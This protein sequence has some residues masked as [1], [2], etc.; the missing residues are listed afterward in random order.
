MNYE[1]RGKLRHSKKDDNFLN[2]PSFYT[3]RELTILP[4]I[5][6]KNLG[7]TKISSE[8]LAGTQ[9]ICECG[10]VKHV[11]LSGCVIIFRK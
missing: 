3:F 9:L 5:T 2:K 10:R 8:Q 6:I 11:I 7:S 4:K 1:K